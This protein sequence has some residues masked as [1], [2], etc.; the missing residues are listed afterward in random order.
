MIRSD[1]INGI[2]ILSLDGILSIREG[3]SLKEMF[4]ELPHQKV[5]VDMQQLTHID[6]AGL[7]VI[8]ELLKL[9]EEQ[10]GAIKL[11]SMNKSVLHVFTL[12]RL[13]HIFEIYNSCD[14]ALQAF[15]HQSPPADESQC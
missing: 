1:E 8:V 2:T 13:H 11:C 12:T 3:A 7:G 15:R 6:S 4:S 14:E 9:A 10:G 5:I